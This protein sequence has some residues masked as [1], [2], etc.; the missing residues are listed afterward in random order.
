MSGV[1]WSHGP[2]DPNQSKSNQSKKDP[3][4]GVPFEAKSL[5]GLMQLFWLP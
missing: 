4:E 5:S 1:H 2:Q 3:T